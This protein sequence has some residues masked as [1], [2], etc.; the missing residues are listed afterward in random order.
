[1][2]SCTASR[3]TV[4][5]TLRPCRR[6]GLFVSVALRKGR[7]PSMEKAVVNHGRVTPVRREKRPRS[8]V[9]TAISRFKKAVASAVSIVT[10]VTARRKVIISP[11]PTGCRPFLSQGRT[12]RGAGK[13]RLRPVGKTLVV[14]LVAVALSLLRVRAA[15]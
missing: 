14:P 6:V 12:N 13:C 11:L 4:R 9:T 2:K 1:M 5:E 3:L 10:T 7:S 15:R 8:Q